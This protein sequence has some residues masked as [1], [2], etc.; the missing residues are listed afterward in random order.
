MATT[1]R[2]FLISLLI[3]SS[4]AG[5]AEGDSAKEDQQQIQAMIFGMYLGGAASQ[6]DMCVEKGYLPS[7]ERSAESQANS[8]IA[9]SE[10]AM[11]SQAMTPFVRKGWD[12]VKQKIHEPDFELTKEKCDF[13]GTQWQKNVTMLKLK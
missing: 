4:F 5:H 12:K 13:I 3:F 8:F 2:Q 9:A 10:Q 7:P 11:H 6:F 1:A